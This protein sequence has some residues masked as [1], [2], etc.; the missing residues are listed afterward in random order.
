M[1][2]LLIAR[3]QANTLFIQS[4]YPHHLLWK[5]YVGEENSNAKNKRSTQTQLQR[6]IKHPKDQCQHQGQCRLYSKHLETGCAVKY[7]LAIAGE[8][9]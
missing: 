8:L 9:G 6:R 7:H 2:R 5:R 3:I 1:M 4:D